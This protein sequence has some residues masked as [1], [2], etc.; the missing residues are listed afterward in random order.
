MKNSAILFLILFLI[1]PTT[2]GSFLVPNGS[3]TDAKIQSGGLNTSSIANSAVTLPKLGSP[4]VAYG[5]AITTT[6]LTGSNV[7][8]ASVSITS[9]GRPVEIIFV[10]TVRGTINNSGNAG[11]VVDVSGTTFVTITGWI[12]RDASTYYWTPSCSPVGASGATVSESC[13]LAGFNFIDFPA[14][15]AHTYTLYMKIYNSGGSPVAN[16][17]NSQMIAVER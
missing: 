16:L 10:P 8:V 14:A 5:T 6:G 3:I 15:G 1:S 9:T 17:F 7:A 11:N 2:W 12:Q 4:N 13:S